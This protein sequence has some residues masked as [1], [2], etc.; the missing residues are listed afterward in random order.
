M[1][2]TTDRSQTPESQSLIRRINELIT[3]N[4]HQ[5]TPQTIRS[6]YSFIPGAHKKKGQIKISFIKRAFSEQKPEV[7][8]TR[9]EG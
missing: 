8:Y 5:K 6:H 1:R 2:Q 4:N 3:Q 9:C 7:S